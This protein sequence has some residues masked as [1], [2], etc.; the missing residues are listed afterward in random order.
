MEKS[1]MWWY[2]PVI[3]VGRKLKIGRSD[4]G[5]KRD[6]ISKIT[7]ARRLEAWVKP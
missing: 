2:I 6:P 1:W 7:S 3:T 4:L 5:R